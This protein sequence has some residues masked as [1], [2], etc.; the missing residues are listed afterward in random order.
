MAFTK[1]S[2]CRMS[3]LRSF[4]VAGLTA[5]CFTRL[6][7]V[8]LIA[9]QLI[10]ISGAANRDIDLQ[11]NISWGALSLAEAR[12][13]W[14]LQDGKAV[15]LGTVKSEGVAALF[16]GFQSASNAEIDWQG[17]EWRPAGLGKLA[18]ELA[19][20][21]GSR[22]RWRAFPS[23]PG[24]S[25]DAARRGSIGGKMRVSMVSLSKS[26]VHPE[27]GY[28]PEAA[29]DVLHSPVEEMRA[30]NG[31][32]TEHASAPPPPSPPSLATMPSTR[33]ALD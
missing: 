19:K 26:R 14:Q 11:Y 7:A 13:Q 3:L 20:G 29:A 24:Y 8:L 17:G 1:N 30:N 23:E 33:W 16:S 25:D 27:V 18:S 4:C 21:G 31:G 5:G 6:I 28:A 22:E 15:I 9:P 2:F 10:S 32:D 12:S